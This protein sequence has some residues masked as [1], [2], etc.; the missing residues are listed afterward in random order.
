M[1]LIDV[2]K[3]ESLIIGLKGHIDSANAP[4]VEKEITE[5]CTDDTTN[6]VIDAE[7]LEYISSAGLRILLRLKKKYPELEVINVSSEVYEVFDMTGFT[8]MME[9]HKAYRTLSVEGCEV[10]GQGAN[11][12]VYRIDPDTIVK[13]YYNPDALPDIQRERELARTALILGVPTAIPYDVVKVGEGYGSVYELVKAQTFRDLLVQ[14][15]GKLEEITRLSVDLLKKIHETEVKPDV[16]PDM[17]ETGLKWVSFLKDY[18]PEE[19][20]DKLYRMTEEIPQDLHMM[21]G[22]YHIKNV[23]MQDGEPLIIDMDTICTGH[24]V[25][26]FASVF[27]A[28]QGFGEV[29]H[30]IV[31][32]FLG[33][34]F[35]T[36]AEIWDRTLKMYFEGKSEEEIRQI[37]DKARIIGYARIMR[38][39]IR[40]DGLN[41]EDGKKQIEYCKGKI[42]ELVPAVDTLVF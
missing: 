26:E 15:P 18:L 37:A 8:E 38:R 16:M 5:A 25:F 20:Y 33:I 17:R 24:P 35:E 36:G 3:E 31:K 4:D 32:N 28:Y 13:V 29:D 6:V 23:M 27:N 12:K 34:P 42:I 22:D 19:I 9:V 41:R 10:I 40:R 11:G 2:K 14:D 1:E 7:K 30:E 39:E 21:H